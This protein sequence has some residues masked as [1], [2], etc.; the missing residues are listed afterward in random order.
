MKLVKPKFCG[1]F[2][3]PP[4]PP[5][6]H[7]YIFYSSSSCCSLF[8][9]NL[10]V[11]VTASRFFNIQM[12]PPLSPKLLTFSL[13]QEYWCWNCEDNLSRLL[14]KLECSMA[15]IESWWQGLCGIQRSRNVVTNDD[16]AG[17]YHR[18]F[19]EI[20]LID[21]VTTDYLLLLPTTTASQWIDDVTT[22]CLLLPPVLLKDPTH[23]W[24]SSRLDK[25][26]QIL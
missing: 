5:P 22:D 9:S 25:P 19:S 23:W 6:P 20:S 8:S 2:P 18:C 7:T 13:R 12:R 26:Y 10:F 15:L 11:I 16:V 24:W 21:D 1:P 4:P 3:P 14:W 17:S